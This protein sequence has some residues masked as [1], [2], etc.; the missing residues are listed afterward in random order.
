[1]QR[2]AL[3]CQIYQR[4]TVWQG[5]T[6]VYRG[7]HMNTEFSGVFMDVH[8]DRGVYKSIHGYSEYTKLKKTVKTFYAVR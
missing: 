7:I 4:S 6:G 2:I 8:R 3:H 5:F 1:M